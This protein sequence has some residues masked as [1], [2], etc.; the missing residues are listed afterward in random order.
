[1]ANDCASERKARQAMLIRKWRPGEK[2]G[3]QR[4]ICAMSPTGGSMRSSILQLCLVALA[5]WSSISLSGEFDCGILNNCRIDGI[6]PSVKWKPTGSC[7]KPFPPSLYYGSSVRE[8]NNAVDSFNR[9][10]S[11]VQSYVS[12]IRTEAESDLKKIP[13]IIRDGAKQA[14]QEMSNEVARARLEIEMMRPR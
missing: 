5:S 12:C 11:E 6:I 13:D 2:S 7:S 9:W 4:T 8:Y 3:G 1:M 14:Q 10:V